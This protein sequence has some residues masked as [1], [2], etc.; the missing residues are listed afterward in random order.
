MRSNSAAATDVERVERK[1]S[2]RID[3][4][5]HRGL[6]HAAVISDADKLWFRH[7]GVGSER[8]QAHVLADVTTNSSEVRHKID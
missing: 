3:V 1:Q 5:N 7:H 2:S 8:I 6:I 4:R